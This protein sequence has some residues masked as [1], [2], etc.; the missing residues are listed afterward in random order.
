ML[1]F[2]PRKPYLKNISKIYPVDNYAKPVDNSSHI[3]DKPVDKPE[4]NNRMDFLILYIYFIYAMLY[5]SGLL[6]ILG[7]YEC[8]SPGN[9]W[10]FWVSSA[11]GIAW[12]WGYFLY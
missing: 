5:I 3:V 7:I 8:F 1:H 4:Y 12:L 10:I 6:I 2:P 11:M 9:K